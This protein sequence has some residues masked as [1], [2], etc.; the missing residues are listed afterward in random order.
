VAESVKVEGGEAAMKL[1]I[2][3]DYVTQFGHLAKEANTLVIPA[4]LSDI[5]SMIALATSIIGKDS[6]PPGKT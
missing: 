5:S 4:N 1:R 3:E 2:A 6:I